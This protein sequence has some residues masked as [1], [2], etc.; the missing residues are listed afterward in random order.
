M[1]QKTPPPNKFQR[2]SLITKQ[3]YCLALYYSTQYFVVPLNHFKGIHKEPCLNH[4]IVMD[5]A[6]NLDCCLLYTSD[7][8]DDVST[9]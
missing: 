6:S 5:L 9:V 1:K 7:A 4:C 2:W 3:S 8:A